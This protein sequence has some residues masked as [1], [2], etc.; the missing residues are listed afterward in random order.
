MKDF[1]FDFERLEVYQV[2]LDFVDHVFELT[3]EFSRDYQFSL[4]EQFR[5]AA[6]S[7]VNN[8]AEGSGKPSKKEKARFYGYSLDSAR[9]CVPMITLSLRRKQIDSGTHDMLREYCVRI[10]RMMAKLISSA[11]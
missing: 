10:S 5:R 2:A 6:L 4:G 11:K 8:I 1:K 7:I 3:G 9:E